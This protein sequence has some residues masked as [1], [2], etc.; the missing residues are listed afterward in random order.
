MQTTQADKWIKDLGLEVHPEGGY[1]RETFRAEGEIDGTALPEK[2]G[3]S[4]KYYTSIYFLL[5]D[6][7]VSHFHRIKS[8]EIWAFHAGDALDIHVISPKGVYEILKLGLDIS[9]GEKPQHIVKAGS[10]FGATL[11]NGSA[12]SLVGCM[13]APGF[14]FADFE[15]A[16]RKDLITLYP[17]YQKVIIELTSDN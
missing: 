14:D 10:W 1:F 16:K 13:V 6:M 4:R 3:A 9:K 7:E 12:Y 17:D 8:D 15:L 2:Y 5:K 11:A